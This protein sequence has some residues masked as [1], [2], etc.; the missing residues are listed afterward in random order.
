[1]K[2]L[3]FALI[4]SWSGLLIAQT[5]FGNLTLTT[6]S[7]N[8]DLLIVVQGDSTV[9]MAIQ[10]LLELVLEGTLD[11]TYAKTDT[12]DEK[13]VGNGILLD[14]KV[15]VK[16]GYIEVDEISTPSAPSSN[17]GRLYMDV[18]DEHIYFRTSSATFD[19]TEGT[20]GGGD[21]GDSIQQLWLK[22]FTNAKPI[23]TV[24]HMLVD[25]L[26]FPFGFGLGNT[27]DTASCKVGALLGK[28]HLEQDS[29][30]FR[31]LI[32]QAFGTNASFNVAIYADE[33]YNDASP[34]Y[35]IWSGTVNTTASVITSFTTDIVGPD[36]EMWA[37]ITSVSTPGNHCVV[38]I[39][40][41]KKRAQ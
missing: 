26:S 24:A 10:T 41:T 9:R 20:G 38:E 27:N 32:T 21:T 40:Y 18:S 1:M 33:T 36:L 6:E 17:K 16:D 19:L 31:K 35:T 34:Q 30:H 5:P 13:T 37:E 11:S 8:G 7:N 29:T 28:K 14:R 22:V 12:L 15:L 39:E 3:I 4:L 2:K 23:D 25:T